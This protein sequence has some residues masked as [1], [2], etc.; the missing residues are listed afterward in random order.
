MWA[1]YA[2]GDLATKIRISSLVQLNR[3]AATAA[4]INHSTGDTGDAASHCLLHCRAG[5]QEKVF[6][7][8]QSSGITC[9]KAWLHG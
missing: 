7:H 8:W 3:F 9:G 4:T 2:A 6:F 5:L 1:H